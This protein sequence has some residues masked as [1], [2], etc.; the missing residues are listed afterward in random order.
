[1]QQLATRYAEGNTHPERLKIGVI[2]FNL[3]RPT[4]D[5]VDRI[6]QLPGVQASL[7]PLAGVHDPVEPSIAR[8]AV[9][10]TTP[11]R[12]VALKSL[13]TKEWMCASPAIRLCWRAFQDNDVVLV[14]GLLG[15]AAITIRLLEL[16]FRK[17]V[18]F[19]VQQVGLQYE[20]R[21][22]WI[23]RLL[24][25]L[26]FSSRFR[27]V[28]QTPPTRE[29]LATYYGIPNDRMI[30][31]PFTGI[32]SNWVERLRHVHPR[33]QVREQMGIGHP[34]AVITLFVGS[35]IELK[36]VDDLIRAFDSIARKNDELWIV[37][38]ISKGQE[39][40][41]RSLRKLAAETN[42]AI[43]FLGEVPY[44]DLPRIYKA[45]DIFAL[46]SRKDTWPKVL[47]EA[48]SAGLPL[49]TTDACGA[50][51]YVVRP[52]RNGFVVEAGNPKAL[53]A[54]LH[55]LHD[56]RQLREQM[57]RESIR[58]A[59][60]YQDHHLEQSGFE[61]LICHLRSDLRRFTGPK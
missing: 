23:I 32:D 13:T 10:A 47:V 41:A 7:Y 60:Q 40:Y 18:A 24:K 31:A 30:D 20:Q 38:G 15:A 4:V 54:A 50:A 14:L 53:A 43:R 17:P 59:L 9:A 57:G 33:S 46:P 51:G 16:V 49:I 34:D 28:V 26:I 2:A 19:V 44:V 37:G 3:C 11:P 21:R 25:R 8:L 52:G 48:A 12:L 36:G 1:M 58:I 45:A 22:H 55:T 61:A 29:V 27:Y 56:S 35:L 42:R 5:L 39:K 6:A